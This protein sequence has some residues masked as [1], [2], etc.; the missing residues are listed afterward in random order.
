MKRT[1]AFVALMGAFGASATDYWV[2]PN[3][4]G[5]YLSPQ[6]PGGD[7]TWL[8]RNKATTGDVI[9]L[10]EGTYDLTKT[11]AGNVAPKLMKS[12]T[13][14]G[15]TDD[16]SKVV[17]DAKGKNRGLIVDGGV[18]MAQIRNL[19]IRNGNAGIYQGG[20][21][22]TTHTP[23]SNYTVSNCVVE[24]CVAAYQGGGANG[25]IWYDS[26]IRNCKVTNTTR[27][28]KKVNTNVGD[29]SGSGGG[30]WGGELHNCTITGNSSFAAGAG[31]AG[32]LLTSSTTAVPCKAY[33]CRITNNYANVGP[34]GGV[35]GDEY[36]MC[37]LKDCW[38]EYNLVTNIV[39][40]PA[41]ETPYPHD[42]RGAGIAYCKA[43]G[44][45]ITNCF[46]NFMDGGM[47]GGAYKSDCADCTLVHNYAAYHGGGA[48]VGSCSNCLITDNWTGYFYG[49]G[50]Y[51]TRTRNC[52]VVN[53]KSGS[54]G[55][56]HS[57]GYHEGD[58][59]FNNTANTHADNK[60]WSY[61]A[62][63]SNSEGTDCTAVNCTVYYN[64]NS[65]PA[66]SGAAMT[67]TV[68]WGNA[69][70]FASTMKPMVNCF[71]K[72]GAGTAPAGS[73]GCK[74]DANDAG[75]VG[76]T[77]NNLLAAA[78]KDLRALALK[79][80]SPCVNAGVNQP[81][82]VGAKDV[83]GT[84]RICQSLVDMGAAELDHPGLWIMVR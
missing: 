77:G 67:N 37:E 5:N 8:T 69:T 16:P 36:A 68:I 28:G 9:H 62:G 23:G 56:G 21:I 57:R 84:A 66:V 83:F 45:T 12:V 53:N 30:V 22:C 39:I 35:G 65:T 20:G 10:L 26:V 38:I 34:G 64:L 43:S 4:T 52:I 70:A 76:G 32:G 24:A 79:P 7:F 18:A 82:M 27:A 48:F 17:L 46:A 54:D 72:T 3:G 71:W 50:T 78:T 61:G 42:G 63:I 2:S 29:T 6:T 47:G 31:L 59:V 1:F 60:R 55:A 81:W 58:I 19:T 14:I 33:N 40:N 73:V 49:G 25:G 13:V 51:N 75:F 15:E 41:T 11:S 80:T 44:C 74:T